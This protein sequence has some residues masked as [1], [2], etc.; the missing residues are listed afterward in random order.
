MSCP[1][2]PCSAPVDSCLCLLLWSPS[3]SYLA[4]LFSHCLLCFASITVFPKEPWTASVLPCPPP[5]MLQ[6]NLL[7]DPLVFLVIQRVCRAL[8]Y[9]CISNK[10]FPCISLLQHSTSSSY[11]VIGNTYRGP[12]QDMHCPCFPVSHRPGSGLLTSPVSKLELWGPSCPMSH[13]QLYP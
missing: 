8:L 2:Q 5:V 9:H 10:F 3:I 6:L 12:F 11:V 7:W 13:R 1:H 4:F